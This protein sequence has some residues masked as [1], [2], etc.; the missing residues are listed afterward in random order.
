MENSFCN[1]KINLK[2]ANEL[3]FTV[4]IGNGFEKDALNYLIK[5]NLR[6]IDAKILNLESKLV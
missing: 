1:F 6:L 2:L 4:V 3:N 5:K